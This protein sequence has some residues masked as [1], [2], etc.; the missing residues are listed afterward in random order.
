MNDSPKEHGK[1]IDLVLS[2]IAL[3]AELKTLVELKSAE[4]MGD[5]WFKQARRLDIP[6]GPLDQLRV[7]LEQFQSKLPAPQPTLIQKVW[8]RV[9]WSWDEKNWSYT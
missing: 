3:L 6:N 1:F 5:A 7:S 2:I 9:M 4:F 8:Q